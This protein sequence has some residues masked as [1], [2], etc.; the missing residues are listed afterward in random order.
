VQTRVSQRLHMPPG[1]G[2][3]PLLPCSHYGQ[4]RQEGLHQHQVITPGRQGVFNG[5]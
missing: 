3:L 2:V 4:V 5:S 1:T